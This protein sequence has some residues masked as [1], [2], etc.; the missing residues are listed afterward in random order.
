MIGTEVI[1]VDPE[2]EYKHLADAVGGTY[3]SVSLNSDS[4]DQSV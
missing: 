1:I 4:R 3:L 2:N